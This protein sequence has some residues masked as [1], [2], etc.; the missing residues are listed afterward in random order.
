MLKRLAQDEWALPMFVIISEDELL[1][2]GQDTLPHEMLETLQQ[3][4]T[5]DY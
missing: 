1:E 5:I 4:N 3:W 2:T